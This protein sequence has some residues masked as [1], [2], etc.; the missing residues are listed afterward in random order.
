MATEPDE[1]RADE[2]IEDLLSALIPDAET[3]D[4]PI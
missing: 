2:R 3:T 4:K 1:L